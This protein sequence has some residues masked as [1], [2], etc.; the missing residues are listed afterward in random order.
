MN[1]KEL[2]EMLSKFDGE[3]EV[4]GMCTDPTGFIYKV[5]IKSIE[6]DNP[7]DT[8]GFSGVDDSEIEWYECYSENKETGEETYIGQKVLLLDLGDV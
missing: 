2:I 6:L 5:K 7:Y 1:V 8:N 3:T 4:L